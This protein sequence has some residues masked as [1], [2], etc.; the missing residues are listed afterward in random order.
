MQV[1]LEVAGPF[2]VV[3]LLRACVHLSPSVVQESKMMIPQVFLFLLFSQLFQINSNHGN[4]LLVW[5]EL[6]PYA[7]APVLT[8]PSSSSLLSPLFSSSCSF[9]GFFFYP[10]F[11]LKQDQWS[12]EEIFLNHGK[13]PWIFM[14]GTPFVKLP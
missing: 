3:E 7:S 6:F 9:F 13:H 2:L 4:L 12:E 11:F 10:I 5:L 1:F 8:L 14:S